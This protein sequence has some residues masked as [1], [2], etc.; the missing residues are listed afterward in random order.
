MLIP[1]AFIKSMLIP[2]VKNQCWGGLNID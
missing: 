2:V 1:G